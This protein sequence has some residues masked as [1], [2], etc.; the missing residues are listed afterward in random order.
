LILFYFFKKTNEL[1]FS[2]ANANTFT[3]RFKINLI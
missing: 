1:N 2:N 3:I